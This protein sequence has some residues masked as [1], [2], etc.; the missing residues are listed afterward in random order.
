MEARPC[1]FLGWNDPIGK[2][3]VDE[4]F[5][6]GALFIAPI[7]TQIQRK[8]YGAAAVMTGDGIV[9]KR[10][11]IIAMVLRAVHILAQAAHMFAQG[12]I[13]YQDRVSLRHA[14]RLR[15]LEERGDPT[16]IHL[17]LEPRRVGEEAGQVG[18]VRALQHTTGDIGQTFIIQD[19][20]A[21]QVMLEMAKLAP[22][23]KK[24]AKNV[25]VGSDDGSGR[26]DGKLHETFALSPR[27]WDRA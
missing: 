16:V 6:S 26:Y 19:D 1:L 20:Q 27:G 8:T 4:R 14:D 12:V 5:P 2:V 24:I 13:Q 22:I 7:Q 21:C 18:F 9:R 25:R 15:L 3:C 17:L 23:L 11:R 10:I